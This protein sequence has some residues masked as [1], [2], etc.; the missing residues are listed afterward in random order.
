MGWINIF[1]LLSTFLYPAPLINLIN[2]DNFYPEK[3]S[4]TTGIKS[5]GAGG[6]AS[7]LPLCYAA[8]QVLKC[9]N[10]IINGG[11]AATK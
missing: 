11:K 8:S 2:I 9:Y 6:E 10:R 5:G 7:M 3:I 4:G 1:K